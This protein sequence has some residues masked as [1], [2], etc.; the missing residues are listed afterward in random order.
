MT[1]YQYAIIDFPRSYGTI[2]RKNFELVLNRKFD[3]EPL[4]TKYIMKKYVRQYITDDRYNDKVFNSDY[5]I[6]SNTDF[7]TQSFHFT[8]LNITELA[9]VKVGMFREDIV[10]LLIS[11][12]GCKQFITDRLWDKPIS[13]EL[14]DNF[15]LIIKQDFVRDC[16]L[17]YK[18]H[19]EMM[20]YFDVVI[21]VNSEKEI[22]EISK[23]SLPFEL[24]TQNITFTQP[25]KI[26]NLE[27]SKNII[28]EIIKPL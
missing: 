7:K 18:K 1:H 6:I 9:Q 16:Y 11:W 15:E 8:D 5:D 26:K 17:L 27:E 21:R 14:P 3:D 24:Y 10:N 22:Y 4:Y 2:T 13:Q 25:N 20:D 28:K 19:L 12:C 23:G